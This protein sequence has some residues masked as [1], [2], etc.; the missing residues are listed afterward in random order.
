MFGGK[1]NAFSAGLF[2]DGG[3]LITVKGGRIKG[4]GRFIAV[5]TFFI[6]EGI[7]S[8][9]DEPVKFEVVPGKLL[10][11]RDRANGFRSCFLLWRCI[12]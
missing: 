7:G 2:C 4:V 9:M 12:T 6:G 5:S 1:N 8:E 3:P 11:S 10:C